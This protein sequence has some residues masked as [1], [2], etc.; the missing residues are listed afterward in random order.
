MKHAIVGPDAL[1]DFLINPNPFRWM[2]AQFMLLRCTVK[3]TVLSQLTTGCRLRLCN[4]LGIGEFTRARDIVPF[5]NKH[6]S[7]VLETIFV[8]CIGSDRHK[9]NGVIVT[10]SIVH[11]TLKTHAFVVAHLQIRDDLVWHLLLLLANNEALLSKR[12]PKY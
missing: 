8:R 6:G 4:G 7:I 9:D 5:V 2:S 12:Q 3:K 1:P 10:E 11:A